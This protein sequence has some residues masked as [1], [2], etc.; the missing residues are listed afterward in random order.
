[1]LLSSVHSC[2]GQL[3]C[4]W[5]LPSINLSLVFYTRFVKCRPA[6][7]A[8]YQLVIML[9]SPQ[10]STPKGWLVFI[11][12]WNPRNLSFRHVLFHEWTHFLI[13]AGSAFYQIWL[14]QLTDCTHCTGQ[15]TPK[16]KANAKPRLLS[17][18]VWIDSGVVVSQHCLALFSSLP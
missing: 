6:M 17:S 9:L 18:L 14:G 16:M 10:L 7:F 5:F 11:T 8:F 4:L 13:L 2:C 12:S 3:Q 15:F 1:M